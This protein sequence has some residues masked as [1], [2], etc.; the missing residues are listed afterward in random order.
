MKSVSF[1]KKSTMAREDSKNEILRQIRKNCI[2]CSGGDAHRV[3]YC[4]ISDCNLW[5]YRFGPG[6]SVSDCD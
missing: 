6:K 4:L 5:L 1:F 2:K 3:N